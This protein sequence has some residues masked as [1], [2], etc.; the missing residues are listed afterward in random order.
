[1][2]SLDRIHKR[3]AIGPEHGPARSLPQG[4]MPISR[5]GVFGRRILLLTIVWIVGFVDT[6]ND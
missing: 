4:V 1:M 3:W 5:R 6:L 2:Q